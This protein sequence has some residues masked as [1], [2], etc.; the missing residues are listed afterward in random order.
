MAISR[1]TPVDA[2]SGF[3]SNGPLVSALFTVPANGL[4]AVMAGMNDNDASAITV[5][6]S[7]AH[8][9]NPRALVNTAGNSFLTVY[10]WF[11]DG[12]DTDIAVTGTFADAFNPFCSMA[13][14]L[15]TGAIDPTVTAPVV[16]TGVNHTVMDSTV[17]PNVEG[18]QVLLAFVDLTNTSLPVSFQAGCS[19]DTVPPASCIASVGNTDSG[20]MFRI[21]PESSS[22]DSVTV[23]ETR[24]SAANSSAAIAYAPTANT[25][26]QSAPFFYETRKETRRERR[27]RRRREIYGNEI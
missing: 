7:G 8:V 11:N 15:L 3:R 16:N 27:M 23:G 4:V 25:S 12:D 1:S 13:V 2:K 17:T 19:A 26:Q 18:S 22:G 10:D 9:W 21:A 5:T 20:W 6:D 14:Q 24:A